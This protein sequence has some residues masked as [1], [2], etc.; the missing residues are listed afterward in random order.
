[1]DM[2]FEVFKGKSF[3]DLCKDIYA[4]Q[5]QR[6]AQIES[7]I[8]DLRKMC[9]AVNDLPMII[10]FIKD[11]INAANVNDEHLIRLAA[12]IQK[13]IVADE[14]AKMTNGGLGMSDEERRQIMAEL[15]TE[16]DAIEK[17]D[18]TIIKVI[19]KK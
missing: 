11:Y 4:N 5:L 8:N 3:K 13:L 18:E 7:L 6:K 19:E 2:D 1:M 15:N 9:V 14:Q 17:S 12:I 10:P 16:F